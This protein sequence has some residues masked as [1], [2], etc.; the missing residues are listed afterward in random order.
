MTLRFSII[1]LLLLPF[2]LVAIPERSYAHGS[3]LTL[4]ATTTEN[5]VDVDYDGF[6]IFAGEPGRFDLKL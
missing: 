2:M 6:S 5:F 3:G 1:A 4:T